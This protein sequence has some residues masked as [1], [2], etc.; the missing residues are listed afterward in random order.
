[1]MN[2]RRAISP[3]SYKNSTLNGEIYRAKNCTSNDNNLDLALKNLEI[4]FLNNE[5]PKNLIKNKINEIKG[6]NF[7]ENPNKA[8]RLAEEN[9]PEIKFFHLSLPFTSFRCGR[10][11]TNLQNILKKYTPN[12]RLKVCFKTI[13]LERII[14]PRLKPYKPLLLTPNTVYLFTCV[15]NDTYIGH[16][17]RLLKIRIQEHGRCDNSHVY[18]HIFQCIKYHE[19]LEARYCSD[20]N[21]TELRH[22]LYEHFTALSTNLPN[23]H[24]RTAYE[25]L[26]IN[27]HQPTLNK[28][29]TFK[30]SNLICSCITRVNDLFEKIE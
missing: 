22:H 15:C 10:I 28:Q 17:S 21:R 24:E 29:L 9:D 19:S 14:L 7:G 5:Y 3:S 30:K 23:W 6:R 2:Y 16:T 13:T 12:Y 4:I 11:A 25:G 27:L 20:P 1:M 18:D 26:M 8:L